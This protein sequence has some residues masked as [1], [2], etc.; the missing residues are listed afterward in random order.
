MLNDSSTNETISSPVGAS[1]GVSVY[2][3][4]VI[5]RS[6]ASLLIKRLREAGMLKDRAAMPAEWIKKTEISSADAAHLIQAH[7]SREGYQRLLEAARYHNRLDTGA[8]WTLSVPADFLAA[9]DLAVTRQQ[10]QKQ[11]GSELGQEIS[12]D[13]SPAKVSEL[14]KTLQQEM[15]SVMQMLS[16]GESKGEK[17]PFSPARF[18]IQL[19][20]RTK[21]ARAEAQIEHTLSEASLYAAKAVGTDVQRSVALSHLDNLRQQMQ[22]QLAAFYEEQ[23]LPLPKPNSREEA[24][25]LRMLAANYV[26]LAESEEQISRRASALAQKQIYL[27]GERTEALLYSKNLPGLLSALTEVNPM[28]ETLLREQVRHRSSLVVGSVVA[29]IIGSLWSMV[30]TTSEVVISRISRFAPVVTLPLLI[31]LVTLI[32]E[33]VAGGAPLTALT[34]GQYVARGL[35]NFLLAL[36]AML[37]ISGVRQYFLNR[38]QIGNNPPEPETGSTVGGVGQNDPAATNMAK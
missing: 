36:G 15:D 26:S 24:H 12:K 20:A 35:W 8:Q 2:P 10:E 7:L 31:G 22:P 17:A 14:A 29:A 9:A 4:D 16:K 19:H 13:F 5:N 38:N 28:R 3:I 23:G 34:L 30:E 6:E 1:V 25:V 27:E 11:K 33:T 37:V 18:W 32:A 21:R